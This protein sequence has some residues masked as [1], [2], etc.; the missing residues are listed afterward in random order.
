[1]KYTTLLWVIIGALS[2]G[3]CDGPPP[4]EEDPGAPAIQ[5]SPEVLGFAAYFVG[6]DESRS[7]TLHNAG[8]G[9]LILENLAVTGSGT[10]TLDDTDTLRT[11]APGESTTA[12]VHFAPVT[13][14]TVF[15]ELQV[16]SNDAQAPVVVSVLSGTGIA[17]VIELSPLLFDFGDQEVGCEM[18][19]DVVI[20]NAGSILL[21]VEEIVFTPSTEEMTYSAYFDLP[22]TLDP[23]ASETVTVVYAGRDEIPDTGYLAVTSDDPLA[24]EAQ[25]ILD[26][27]AHLAQQVTDEFVWDTVDESDILWIM[28]NSSSMAN[29]QVNPNY[30]ALLDIFDVMDIDYH[31][32]VVT[33]DDPEFQGAT[34]V[35]TPATPDVHAAF[36]AAVTVGTTGSDTNTGLLMGYEALTPPL[37]DIGGTNEGFLREEAALRIIIVS[38]SDDESPGTV[39]DIVDAYRALKANPDYV[40]IHAIVDTATAVR[41]P[42][43]ASRTG[44]LTEDINNPNWTNTL[45]GPMMLCLCWDREI[46][47]LSALA[48]EETIEVEI[49]GAPMTQ[50][51][52]YDGVYNA[53]VFDNDFLPN[54]EDVITVRYH[55]E[56]MCS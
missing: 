43:A 12:R 14:G 48:V 16:T 47:E 22:L 56:G 9:T 25:T 11:L 15:A 55:V 28:D 37:S 24:P 31:M 52:Y 7:L 26:G 29:N 6:G 30:S 34:P 44:G 4:D 40:M 33:T 2:L 46:L 36:A 5:I 27:T 38:D 23:G 39:E 18:E 3:G 51:W 53:V 19:Q 13:D 50:G 21:T 35:M 45:A 32:A 49:N 8:D 10:F 1:M 17:P 20:H 54:Q 42:E 41:Y